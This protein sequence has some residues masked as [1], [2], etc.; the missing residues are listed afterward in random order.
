MHSTFID[1]IW[2]DD[3]AN[4][5]LISKLNKVFR[6]FCVIDISSKYTWVFLL[7]HKKRI[8]ITNTFQIF[9]DESNRRVA[10]TKERK[11]NKIWVDKGSEFCN[12]SIKSWLQ[13][14]YI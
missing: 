12:R 10:R 3:L 14:N 7:K 13:K 8:S 9:L 6:F 2:D 4:M 1:N 11:P 5:Q